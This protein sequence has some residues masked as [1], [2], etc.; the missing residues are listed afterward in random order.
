LNRIFI[1]ILFL[2][3]I[4][5]NYSFSLE[6]FYLKDNITSKKFLSKEEEWKK[7]EIIESKIDRIRNKIKNIN[8]LLEI[9]NLKKNYRLIHKKKEKDINIILSKSMQYLKLEKPFLA[10]KMLTENITNIENL[11]KENLVFAYKIL[12]ESNR[13]IKNHKNTTNIC[14]KMLLKN[15]NDKLLFD[16][17]WKLSCSI[18]FLKEIRQLKNKENLKKFKANLYLWVH[19]PEIKKESSKNLL[20]SIFNSLAI[21]KIDLQKSIQYL[22]ESI[23][24][25]NNFFLPKAYLIL[26]LMLYESGNKK[27]SVKM[28]K[29]LIEN[30]NFQKN[31]LAEKKIAQLFLARIQALSKNYSESE[32]LYKNLLLEQNQDD[33]EFL[34][35]EHKKILLEYA[36]VLYVQ[37]KY[38]QSAE[39]YKNLIGNNFLK[40]KF[41]KNIMVSNFILIDILSRN[42]SFD[43]SQKLLSFLGKSNSDIKFLKKTMK[44]NIN[45][46]DIH[47]LFSLSQEY[48]FLTKE[49]NDLI[50]II[51]NLKY[52]KKEFYEKKL[53]F[54]N[55]IFNINYN[56]K[57]NS[58]YQI[59]FYL[60]IFLEIF[61]EFKE[62]ILLL[63]SLEFN[64]WKIS[65]LKSEY[66]KNRRIELLKRIYLIDDLIINYKSKKEPNFGKLDDSIIEKNI[67]KI[68]ETKSKVS[69]LNFLVQRKDFLNY[70]KEVKNQKEKIEEMSHEILK[71]I[72]KKNHINDIQ[73]IKNN[74][75]K[76]MQ[77]KI[78]LME[79]TALSFLFLHKEQREKYSLKEEED[80]LDNIDKIWNSIFIIYA[81][82]NECILTLKSILI[83]EE[84]KS[85]SDFYSLSK[86]IENQEIMTNRIKDELI[87]NNQKNLQ[88]I[89]KNSEKSIKKFQDFVKIK[90]SNQYSKISNDI[91]ANKKIIEESFQEREKWINTVKK[92]LEMDLFR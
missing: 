43:I 23:N 22:Q 8:Y 66:K 4:K 58:K 60:D 48:G 69:S 10:I 53:S 87:K 50:K 83:K 2:I 14:L 1:Y 52:L 17:K 44:K 5:T 27:E 57:K 29:F 41:S 89:F 78:T 77:K 88:I 35:N 36:Y 46:K 40:L 80:L 54:T 21:K 63:D 84:I 7:I 38:L 31:T 39:E 86:E 51:S 37:K 73:F 20:I 15:N 72:L 9:N 76:N 24:N 18:E 59:S 71:N 6:N 91:L 49:I 33:S 70:Y 75:Y 74:L 12:Y 42:K 90:L 3:N 65:S 85:F 79:E 61:K 68:N 30:K 32:I 62:T 67:L 47:I 28:I 45:L 13:K 34:K 55:S 16:N 56:I 81:E 11:A 26:S 19:S 25:E 92:S 64:Q 82:F